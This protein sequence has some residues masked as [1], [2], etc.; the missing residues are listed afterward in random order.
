MVPRGLRLGMGAG[1]LKRS[2]CRLETS[3]GAF[4]TEE[5][6]RMTC[7]TACLL[8]RFLPS[9]PERAPSGLILAFVQT[10]QLRAIGDFSR[11]RT[12]GRAALQHPR[13]DLRVFCRKT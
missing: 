10:V 8:E 1:G 7:I 12:A 6:S 13:H 5:T 2:S 11:L 4:N 3:S 9:G